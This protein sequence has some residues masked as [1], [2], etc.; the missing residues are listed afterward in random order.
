MIS[1]HYLHY[2]SHEL[3]SLYRYNNKDTLCVFV[4][5]L[6]DSHLNYQ[7]LLHE[8]AL[9]QY[10][11]F[12]P[13]LINHGRSS[14]TAISHYELVVHCLE[15]QIK[16][17][18]AHYQSVCFIPH[19]I[20]G[21]AIT[22]LYQRLSKHEQQKCSIF[23]LETSIT[24]HG[25]FLTKNLDESLASG[26][27]LSNWFEDFCQKNYSLGMDAIYLR[28]YFCA[29]QLCDKRAFKTLA[30]ETRKIATFENKATFTNTAGLAYS[31]LSIPKIYCYADKGQQLPSL[32][33]LKQNHL[34]AISIDAKSHWVLQENPTDT[35][36]ALTQFIQKAATGTQ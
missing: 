32:P 10:D 16:P 11:I 26:I 8:T 25:S 29:L 34:K 2:Q 19:S 30:L 23:A 27:P 1:A 24:Q 17:L 18:L 3:F 20:A 15:A 33:F 36:S 4:H 5:G 28:S 13:D 7:F 9:H 22:K 35:L 14:H 6:G 12:I 21:I 31:E